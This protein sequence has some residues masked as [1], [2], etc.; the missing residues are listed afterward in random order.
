MAVSWLVLRTR[1]RRIR[2]GLP[3][4]ADRADQSGPM[5]PRTHPRVWVSVLLVSRVWAERDLTEEK[6]SFGLK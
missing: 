6:K 1:P 2:R 5:T 3:G 4:R